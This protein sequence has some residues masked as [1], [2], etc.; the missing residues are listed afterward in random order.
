MGYLFSNYASGTLAT[1]IDA[2]ETTLTLAGGQGALFPTP[3]GGDVFVVVL[4]DTTGNY[5]V[6]TCTARTGDQLTVVR[7]V[8]T[9]AD[10]FEAGSRVELRLT[11]AV[12]TTLLQKSGGTLTGNLDLDGN[13]LRNAVIPTPSITGGTAVGTVL[14]APDN[15]AA[16][17]FAVPNGGATP[18]VGGNTLWHTGNDGSGSGLD[19]DTVDGQHAS[20]FAAAGHTHAYA[21]VSHNH[22]A[23]DINAGTLSNA[24]LNNNV[25]RHNTETSGVIRIVTSAPAN[26]DGAN[27]DIFLVVA[28]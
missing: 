28:P 1:T 17:E 5:E 9:P 16:N 10:G 8:E 27:G 21:P 26:G 2:T 6:C 7:G 12:L 19:A 20:A 14:R 23:S 13:E 22:N 3:S 11:A 18:T 4:E 15:G 24:R 25:L